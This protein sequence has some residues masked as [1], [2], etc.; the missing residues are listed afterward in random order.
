MGPSS[1]RNHEVGEAIHLTERNF[2]EV[3]VATEGLVMVDFWAEWCGPCRAIAPVLQSIPTILF[4]K[5][6]AV[7]DRVL[8]AAPKAVLQDLVNARA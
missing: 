8:G 1:S 6:G 4:F 7:V 2:D 3:V 5:D